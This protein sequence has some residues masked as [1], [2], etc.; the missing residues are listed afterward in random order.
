MFPSDKLQCNS[1]DILPPYQSFSSNKCVLPQK[2][3][4]L[5][6]LNEFNDPKLS[7]IN[8]KLQMNNKIH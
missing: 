8:W 2:R 1:L 5:S 6:N 3:V 7:L 4:Y